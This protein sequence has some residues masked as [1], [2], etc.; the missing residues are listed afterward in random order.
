M[1]KSIVKCALIKV[2][3]NRRK[4]RFTCTTITYNDTLKYNKPRVTFVHIKAKFVHNTTP[5]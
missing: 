1:D 2:L 4:K 3:N 5:L